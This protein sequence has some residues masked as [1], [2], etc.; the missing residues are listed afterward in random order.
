MKVVLVCLCTLLT[1]TQLRAQQSTP[2]LTLD[3]SVGALINAPGGSFAAI[4]GI[5]SPGNLAFSVAEGS[6]RPHLAAGTDIP[7]TS[8]FSIGARL[9]YSSIQTAA[10]AREIVPIASPQGGIIQ[11][12]LEHRLQYS[13]MLLGLEP[14]VRVSVI[15]NFSAEFALPIGYVLESPYTQELYFINPAGLQFVDGEVDQITARGSNMPD[16][17]ALTVSVALRADAQFPVNAD[18]TMFIVPRIGIQQQLNGISSAGGASTLFTVGVGL[19]YTLFQTTQSTLPEQETPPAFEPL[20]IP[21]PEQPRAL[22]IVSTQKSDTTVVFSKEISQQQT[23]LARTVQDTL[24][25]NDTLFITSTSHY[26]TLV[27]KM[28]PILS[29]SV[30]VALLGDDGKVQKNGKLKTKKVKQTRTAPFMPVVVFDEHRSGIP[31]RYIQLSKN[32][33]T[34]FKD[35]NAMIDSTSHWQYH[36]LNILGS[37]MA[38][39]PSSTCVLMAFDD[40]T[41]NGIKIVEERVKN[42]REYLSTTFGIALKRLIP[43]LRKG[44]ASQQPWV[45]LVDSSRTLL[46]PL[47]VVDTVVETQLP[48]VRI[49][50]DVVSEAGIT[51]WNI[52]CTQQSVLLAQFSG[53]GDV[54][55]FVDWDMLSTN[56]STSAPVLVELSVT[57]VDGSS[58]RTEPARIR[59]QETAKPEGSVSAQQIQVLRVLAPDF[60]VTPD[61]ELFAGGRNFGAVEFYPASKYDEPEYLLSDAPVTKMQPNS[62]AWFRKNLSDPELDFYRLAELYKLNK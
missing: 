26:S 62:S 18:K 14:L 23:V 52:S 59:M 3:G 51:S 28:A 13:A 24:R 48:K 37:R 2:I 5:P 31:N 47:V 41:D 34:G 38:L 7:L 22:Q 29:A 39:A 20:P 10:T 35:R 46:K 8:L 30:N 50:P 54:P 1:I 15:D 61:E 9:S 11:A 55:Q 45:F 12:T 44:Q 43:D 27:P 53:K 49:T 56:T 58:A 57:D 32:S 6:I 33:A 40:G 17:A 16:A 42:V 21:T 4:S 19:R 60:L 25:R 36:V